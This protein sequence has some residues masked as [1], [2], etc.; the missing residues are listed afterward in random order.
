MSAVCAVKSLM[1]DSSSL[2]P[3]THATSV[4]NTI[5][6]FRPHQ[7]PDHDLDTSQQ[8]D[9]LSPRMTDLGL[10]QERDGQHPSGETTGETTASER[11]LYGSNSPDSGE[12][13]LIVAL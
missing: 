12:F 8:S 5:P 1:S 7:Y 13:L 6:G 11:Y 10:D 9:G 4:S 3:H 2:T